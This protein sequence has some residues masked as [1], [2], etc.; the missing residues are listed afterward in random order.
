MATLTADELN[1]IAQ[2]S[3]YTGGTFNSTGLSTS[4]TSY[5]NPN[6]NYI[7]TQPTVNTSQPSPTTVNSTPYTGTSIV[8][9]LN[10]SGQASDFA[11][12]TKLATQ[13]GIQN[14]QGTA[15]QNTQLLQKYRNSFQQAQGQTAPTT[16]GEGSAMVNKYTGGATQMPSIN[17]VD[18]LLAQDKGYQDLLKMYQDYNSSQKQQ[19]SL[20]AEYDRLSKESGLEGIN[21]QLINSKNIINGTEQDIRNEI[22]AVGG[23]GTESQVQALASARNKGLIQNYNN[24]VD[25]ANN[26]QDRIKTMV[27]LSAQDRQYAQQNFENQMNFQEQ[28][29]NYREKF[30][31]NAKEGFNAVLNKVGYAGLYQA[32]QNN[33]QELALA[34]RTLGLGPGGLAQLATY[35]EPLSEMDQLD[36]RYKKAQISNINSEIA[37]RNFEMQQANMPGV[38]PP[39]I[40]SKIE[41]SGEYKTINGLLPAIQAIRT[42]QD[43]ITKY[44]TVSLDGAESGALSSAYGNALAAWKTL[45]GLGALSGA[46]FDLAEN[47][48]PKTGLLAMTRTS[49]ALAKLGG[50]L[51]NAITQAENMTDRLS[52]VYP[53]A[54]TL[55]QS[56]LDDIL[57]T[58]NPEKYTRGPDGLVYEIQ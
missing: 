20:S 48:I 16:T 42:Y 11:S 58:A 5:V 51:E 25:M 54:S 23:F 12:R 29:Q 35:K 39:Q 31:N 26:I 52:K 40:L 32:L 6:A 2:Q 47:A 56:Q 53:Q 57:L 19:E 14:Y 7:G 50:S 38:V 46:D 13:Y 3:G 24:L 27:G 15:D 55:L 18:T 4:P 43:A 17:P 44:G 21:T 34:E 9:A 41:S 28:M 22:S 1:S 37:K 36:I 8:D 30:I 10:S 49:T 33:P 45:A